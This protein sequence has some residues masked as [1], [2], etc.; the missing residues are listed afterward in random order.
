MAIGDC[1]QPLEPAAPLAQEELRVEQDF[2]TTQP[3]P[4]VEPLVS[5]PTL[6]VLPAT[7]NPAVLVT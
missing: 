2:A 6:K 1:G 5:D 7:H 4:T 3:L